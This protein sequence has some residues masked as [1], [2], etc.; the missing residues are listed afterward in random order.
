MSHGHQVWNSFAYIKDVG[1]IEESNYPYAGMVRTSHL[2]I[3]SSFSLFLIIE[4]LCVKYS[5]CPALKISST[6]NRHRVKSYGRVTIGSSSLVDERA[7]KNYVAKNGP[8]SV[9]I[10]ASVDFMLYKSGIF[11]DPSCSTTEINH[12]V[13]LIG[14][15]TDNHTGMDYWIIRN[16]WGTSW[17]MVSISDKYDMIFI[18]YRRLFKH[19]IN[20]IIFFRNRADMVWWLVIDETTV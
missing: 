13:V 5:S 9:Y 19:I 18:W 8:V 14:Y 7:L 4:T 10:D 2:L 6:S 16:S 20:Y 3:L 12:A 1:I 17:G 15:G 11:Y